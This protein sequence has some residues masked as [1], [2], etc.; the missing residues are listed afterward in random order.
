M[1]LSAHHT[2]AQTKSG[3]LKKDYYGTFNGDDWEDFLA[4]RRADD[5]E[6]KSNVTLK[7]YLQTS[8]SKFVKE[9]L[10]EA[11]IAS[12]VANSTVQPFPADATVVTQNTAGE[13]I[14]RNA[15]PGERGYFH[16]PTGMYWLSFSCGN[17]TAFG[18]GPVS[19]TKKSDMAYTPPV[20]ASNPNPNPNGINISINGN[21]GKGG[22]DMIDYSDY[23]LGRND[24]KENYR[25]A[26]NFFVGAQNAKDCNPCGSSGSSGGYTSANFQIAQSAPVTFQQAAPPAQQ[27]VYAQQSSGSNF[28]ATAGAVALG[29]TVGNVAGEGLNRW[30]YGA[31]PVRVVGNNYSNYGGSY[32]Q[33]PRN[34]D[35]QDGNQQTG[36]SLPYNSGT[37]GGRYNNSFY[38]GQ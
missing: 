32:T 9:E 20:P 25:D 13:W 14:K 8:V 34:Q 7:D 24:T 33:Y 3:I 22:A 18:P 23:S 27:V 36:N 26:F 4:G 1:V 19:G 21:Q 6:K 10:K 28:W 16:T 17:L 30:I 2:K 37:G 12:A 5:F 15:Y 29:S 31:Q 35:F 38:Q 11:S